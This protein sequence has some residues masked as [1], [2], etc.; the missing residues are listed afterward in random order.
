VVVR[1][2]T[3]A[4]AAAEDAVG[5]VAVDDAREVAEQLM[6]ADDP[7]ASAS[8]AGNVEPDSPLAAK[9]AV[10]HLNK[11]LHGLPAFVRPALAGA[12]RTQTGSAT[13]G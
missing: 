9:I 3:D 5:L 10:E 1:P 4:R 13:T 12:Q 2:G 11:L 8:A 7:T 6:A